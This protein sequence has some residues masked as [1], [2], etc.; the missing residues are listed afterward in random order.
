MDI[1]RIEKIREAI[2]ARESVVIA[3]SGG[4]VDSTTL[5]A[6]AFE[7]LGGDRALAVTIDSPLFPDTSLKQL[8]RLPV[9]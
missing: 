4:G 1:A 7:E 9:K 8:P 5:A 3:F 6:L 2:K